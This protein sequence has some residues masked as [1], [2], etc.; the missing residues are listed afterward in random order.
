MKI[1]HIEYSFPY[2]TFFNMGLGCH[3]WTH[4]IEKN[5]NIPRL[6]Y[7]QQYILWDG[8]HFINSLL[9][10]CCPQ[11]WLQKIC[12]I[13][14]ICD[15]PQR[16][17][18][19]KIQNSKTVAALKEAIKD[20]PSS[21]GDFNGIDAKYFDL[22]K[23]SMGCWCSCLHIKVDDLKLCKVQINLK[24]DRKLHKTIN[25]EGD[26]EGG[27]KLE[28][29]DEVWEVLTEIPKKHLHIIV[30]CPPGMYTCS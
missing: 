4:L 17:F 2:L 27:E 15:N 18:S 1:F 5:N 21:K 10:T 13:S 7:T 12:L 28:P 14:S 11:S 19:V 22:W 25:V 23:V 16:V 29:E 24:K 9:H 6:L 8:L 26:L 3:S 30:Q 20:S